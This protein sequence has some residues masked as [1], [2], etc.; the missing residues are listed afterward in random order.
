MNPVETMNMIK[1]MALLI[2]QY[3]QTQMAALS[4]LRDIGLISNEFEKL[5]A[6]SGIRSSEQ[7]VGYRLS[8]EVR[9]YLKN[10]ISINIQIL[11]K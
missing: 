5:Q 9:D 8:S 3:H 1:N 2:D 10:P 4:E 11:D 6:N 7:L